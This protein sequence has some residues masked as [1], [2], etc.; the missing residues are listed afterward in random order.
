MGDHEMYPSHIY[1]LNSR[2]F[3]PFKLCIEDNLRY[4]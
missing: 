4:K 3:T 2:Y 1:S